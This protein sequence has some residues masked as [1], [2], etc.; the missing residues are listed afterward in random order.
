MGSDVD[1]IGSHSLN[2]Y[3]VTGDGV[4]TIQGCDCEEQLYVSILSARINL[5]E[6]SPWA[7]I[8]FCRDSS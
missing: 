7:G 6:R 2:V 4:C 1:G 5:F 8:C 3:C